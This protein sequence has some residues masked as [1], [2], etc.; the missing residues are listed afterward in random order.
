[1]MIEGILKLQKIKEYAQ[2]MY[3]MRRKKEIYIYIS[4]LVSIASFDAKLTMM[5]QPSFIGPTDNPFLQTS[6]DDLHSS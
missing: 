6:L 1:M 3:R 2:N 5:T 4:P